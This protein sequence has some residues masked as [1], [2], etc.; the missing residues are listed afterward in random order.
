MEGSDGFDLDE[1]FEETLSSDDMLKDVR[2]PTETSDGPR[3]SIIAAG[4]ILF[5][6]NDSK[7]DDVFEEICF[8]II[9]LEDFLLS[10]NSSE[11]FVLSSSPSEC[12]LSDN[13]SEYF[14]LPGDFLCFIVDVSE[15]VLRI[16]EGTSEE[17]SEDV[18]SSEYKP[19]IP[20]VSRYL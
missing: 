18:V 7:G 12:L 17:T 13:S 3:C 8:A 14:L 20:G 19:V 9:I 4:C 15:V 10:D 11:D 6:E 1:S 16:I 5:S 2:V